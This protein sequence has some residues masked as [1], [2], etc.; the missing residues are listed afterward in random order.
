MASVVA[1]AVTFFISFWISTERNPVG[2]YVLFLIA[3]VNVG[4]IYFVTSKER[5]N[6]FATEAFFLYRIVRPIAFG[7]TIVL[8]AYVVLFVAFRFPVTE[9]TWQHTA[10]GVFFWAVLVGFVEEFV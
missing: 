3:A 10:A 2:A 1:L 5:V 9:L 8:A 4:L 7:M 6:I